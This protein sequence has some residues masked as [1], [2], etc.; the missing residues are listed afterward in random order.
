[1]N[2]WS[3]H[4]STYSADAGALVPDERPVDQQDW[5]AVRLATTKCDDEHRYDEMLELN[6]PQL[7]QA[8]QEKR[9]G[10]VFWTTAPLKTLEDSL[11]ANNLAFVPHYSAPDQ[12]TSLHVP[13]SDG[14]HRAA[15]RI[16]RVPEDHV[17]LRAFCQRVQDELR[18][19]LY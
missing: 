15:V 6:W 2:V 13:F 10:V 19:K 7:V 1:M 4:V 9:K 12:C 8:W 5:P 18:L 14:K 17:Q 11:H 16:R 3:D